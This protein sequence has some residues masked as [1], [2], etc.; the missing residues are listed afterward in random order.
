M[1]LRGLCIFM[2]SS[3]LQKHHYRELPPEVQR[4]LGTVPDQFV[5]Y[6]TS[7]FPRLLLHAYHAMSMCKEERLFHQYYHREPSPVWDDSS[8]GTDSGVTSSASTPE[9][10]TLGADGIQAPS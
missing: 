5:A 4:S 9:E 7:R 2:V 10:E 1:L 3:V 6:F 8:S